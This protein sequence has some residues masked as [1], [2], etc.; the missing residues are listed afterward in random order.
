MKILDQGSDWGG[1]RIRENALEAFVIERHTDVDLYFQRHK[2]NLD[3][4]IRS[5]DATRI[6]A[7]Y[8][9]DIHDLPNLLAASV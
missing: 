9:E 2:F 7:I 1:S 6:E 5:S 8:N 4:S 3:G